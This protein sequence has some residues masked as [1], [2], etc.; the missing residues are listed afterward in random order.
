MGRRMLQIVSALLVLLSLLFWV[1][2]AWAT[3]THGQSEGLYSHLI[4]HVIFLVAM[5]Y[6]CLKL[7]RSGMHRRQGWKWITRSAFFFSLW[8]VTTL[9]VHSY[10]EFIPPTAFVRNDVG[11]VTGF[12]AASWLDLLYYLGRHD[13]LFSLP[14]LLFLLFGLRALLRQE[15][16]TA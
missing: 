7:I 4:A 13:H 16:G 5:V 11:L 14:A 9:F 6:F 2:P 1:G 12:F 8:N 15:G 10:R 3:Q